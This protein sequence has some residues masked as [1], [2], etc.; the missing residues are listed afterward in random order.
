MK[1]FTSL[2]FLEE[3]WKRTVLA[4]HK[5]C[6]FTIWIG[7]IKI[8]VKVCVPVWEAGLVPGATPISPKNSATPGVSK[9]LGLRLPAGRRVSRKA[10]QAL[11]MLGWLKT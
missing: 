2:L 1:A 7:S 4:L 11:K 5:R 6:F 9:P 8:M 3:T 10:E